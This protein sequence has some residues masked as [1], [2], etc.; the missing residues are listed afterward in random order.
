[1]AEVTFTQID[2]REAAEVLGCHWSTLGRYRRDG[3][4]IEGIHFIKVGGKFRYIKELLDDL[5][6]V[7]LNVNSRDHQR[8]IELY[9]RSMLGNQLKGRGVAKMTTLRTLP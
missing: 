7:G 4:L 6:K 5:A 1:M 2:K 3:K 8:A 9:R